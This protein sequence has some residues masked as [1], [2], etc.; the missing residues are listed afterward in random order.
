M[1]QGSF[2]ALLLREWYIT[3]RNLLMM[4]AI[5]SGVIT[6]C[7]LISLSFYHGNLAVL[8]K[9]SPET[10]MQIIPMLKWIVVACA[11]FMPD[12]VLAGAALDQNRKWAHFIR[13]TPVSPMRIAAAKITMFSGVYLLSTG[14]ALGYLWFITKYNDMTLDRGDAAIFASIMIS[15]LFFPVLE[16]A[17]ITLFHV[18]NQDKAGLCAVAVVSIPLVGYSIYKSK[19]D[20][21]DETE[22]SAYLAKLLTFAEDY[23]LPAAPF[24]IIAL[25]CICFCTIYAGCKKGVK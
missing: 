2:G 17:V 14:I 7:L 21:I 6:I 1:K 19:F 10:K 3:R 22:M 12:V 9:D 13:T 23:I 4:L 8:L 20:P 15:L 16:L 11:S 5:I 18:E 24:I 25:L